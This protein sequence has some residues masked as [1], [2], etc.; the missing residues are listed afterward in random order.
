MKPIWKAIIVIFVVIPSISF[1]Q[2]PKTDT[3]RKAGNGTA[4]FNNQNYNIDRDYSAPEKPAPP[5]TN[6]VQ[7]SAEAQAAGAKNDFGPAINELTA[8]IAAMP[9]NVSALTNRANFYYKSRQADKALADAKAALLFNNKNYNAVFIAGSALIMMRQPELAI[10]Y[11][12]T[13]LMLKPNWLQALQYRGKLLVQIGRNAEAITDLTKVIEME[14]KNPMNFLL[15]A[16]AYYRKYLINE[17]LMD[18]ITVT[19]MAPPESKI[20]QVAKKEFQLP[21]LEYEERKAAVKGAGQKAAAEVNSGRKIK[22]AYFEKLHPLN[23][24]AI[25]LAINVNVAQ[26]SGYD[27]QL[28]TAKNAFFANLNQQQELNNYTKKELT[29]IGSPD[30]KDMLALI[31][32]FT[33]KNNKMIA[34]VGNLKVAY[35]ERSAPTYYYQ[36][37]V[38]YDEWY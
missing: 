23:D 38:D 14:P 8:A 4:Q 34:L 11:F 30:D 36:E 5:N 35:V 18:Y 2:Q 12:D 10:K 31:D 25:T 24:Q 33:E 19:N 15:R 26:Q 28:K 20:F 32:S 16:R 22:A 13:A 27:S 21:L 9:N 1:A 17:S 7:L 6:G 37:W 29:K 3:T